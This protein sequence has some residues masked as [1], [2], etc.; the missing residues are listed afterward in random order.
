[1][2]S[3]SRLI[4]CRQAAPLG[5]GYDHAG[6]CAGVLHQGK[7]GEQG[8]RRHH[9]ARFGC[10][11]ARVA[12]GRSWPEDARDVQ[13]DEWGDNFSRRLKRQ[14]CA[15]SSLRPPAGQ[16]F[17]AKGSP[18]GEHADVWVALKNAKPFRSAFGAFLE[19]R[20]LGIPCLGEAVIPRRVPRAAAI[21]FTS[22]SEALPAIPLTHMNILAN[23]RGHRRR[24]QDRRTTV[25]CPCF[26]RSI[27][28][29]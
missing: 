20:L 12:Q 17:G 4:A 26:R 5:A 7:S 10:S 27:P 25:C 22:G 23:C 19:F 29:G 14:A 24:A 28:S 13:L 2:R 6:F 8:A 21:L 11:R 15:A 1:M 3:P 9:A 16:A 18:F